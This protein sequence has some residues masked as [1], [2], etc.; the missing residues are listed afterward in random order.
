MENIKQFALQKEFVLA[1]LGQLRHIVEKLN[2][3]GIDSADAIAK[4]E[5]AAKD[6]EDDVLR[7]ALLGAFSDG[8]T[9]VIAGWLGQ[10]MDDMK[11]DT[12]ESSDRLAIYRPDNLPEGCEIVDTPGLFGDKEHA[13]SGGQGSI[14]YGEITKRYIS[15]AHL[16]FYV[17]DATNPLKDSHRDIVRWVLRDLNKLSSTL[18]IINKMDE[19]AD[20]RD[21][22]DFDAQA[23][24]KTD[25]LLCKLDRFLDL[26][27]AER[28]TIKVV[29]IASNPNG[30]GLDFWFSKGSVYE[31]RSRIRVLKQKTGEILNSGTRNVLIHKT[32][33]DVI[34]D[35][36]KQRLATAQEEYAQFEVL[37]DQMR[38]TN[39]RCGD[40]IKRAVREVTAAKSDLYE[41]LRTAENR[42]IG[43]I[44]SLRRED[45]SSFL[46]DEIGFSG[47]DVGYKL[48]MQI[49]FACERAFEQASNVLGEISANIE[50]QLDTSQRFA[51]TVA[52][53]VGSMAAR[54][55]QQLSAMPVE[56]IKT[57]IFVARDLLKS[58]TGIAIK[59]KPWGAAKWASSISKWAGPIG[60]AIQLLSEAFEVYRAREAENELNKIKAELKDLVT[61]HF[62]TVYD[63]LSDETLVFST[64]AP[65]IPTLKKIVQQQDETVQQLE[66]RKQLM[67][68]VRKEL[69][70]FGKDHAPSVTVDASVPA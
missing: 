67:L 69:E 63:I 1:S 24:I 13:A 5:A 58:T 2:G 23:R 20:L 7:V 39:R 64:F 10:I 56:T 12:D 15:E 41:E 42:L 52:V 6:V 9:S 18:F 68:E 40:D 29:C 55:A 70:A 60:I 8:K 11:I 61:T 44:R 46:E 43:R 27:P 37:A 51:D 19:V 30:R 32:G 31:E 57:G 47:S 45:V 53:S 33:M 16:V 36:V 49:E 38:E 22:E 25:N 66:K 21:E 50:R 62:K 28:Q 59:F 65:Q 4:I 17:V 54:A 26:T 3:A 14:E 48:R 34:S 35:V